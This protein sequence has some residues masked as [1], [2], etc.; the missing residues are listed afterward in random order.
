MKIE[1]LWDQRASVEDPPIGDCFRFGDH[2]PGMVCYPA[3]KGTTHQLHQCPSKNILTSP[4]NR[5]SFDHQ[6]AFLTV[7]SMC[8]SLAAPLPQR[9]AMASA[10]GP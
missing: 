6:F 1:L 4:Y 7:R 10:A 9:W 3:Q 2:T 5:R 8:S